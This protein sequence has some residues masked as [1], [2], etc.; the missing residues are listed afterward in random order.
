[1]AGKNP[2]E[3]CDPQV[4][5]VQQQVG[6]FDVLRCIQNQCDLEVNPSKM[7]GGYSV[8][9]IKVVISVLFHQE[10]NGFKKNI[11]VLG[12]AGPW[13]GESPC[14]LFIMFSQSERTEAC[15][16]KPTIQSY[17]QVRSMG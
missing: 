12:E 9:P 10:E 14:S 6:G 8:T 15:I 5:V 13:T 1:M 17:I 16:T 7:P 4:A 11:A 3:V 2:T